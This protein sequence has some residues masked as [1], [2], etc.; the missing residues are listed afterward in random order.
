MWTL[1]QMQNSQFL[2]IITVDVELKY[3][4]PNLNIEPKI[5]LYNHYTYRFFI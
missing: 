1:M 3:I 5:T 4:Y 2:F